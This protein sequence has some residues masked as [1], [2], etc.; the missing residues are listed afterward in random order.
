[1]AK[2][3]VH[4]VKLSF[5]FIPALLAAYC[6]VFVVVKV[7]F[8]KEAARERYRKEMTAAL[9][10]DNFELARACGERLMRWSGE[11]TSAD[12]MGWASSLAG[13]GELSLAFD[14]LNELAPNDRPGHAPAHHLKAEMLTLLFAQTGQRSLLPPLFF[15]LN[16]SDRQDSYQVNLGFATYY[17][18]TQQPDEAIPYLK[19]AAAED[20][21]LYGKLIT[22]YAQAQ[23]Q[24]AF[25]TT[26]RDALQ[27]VGELVEQEPGN[28]FSRIEYARLFLFAGR[29]D[30]GLAVLKEGQALNPSPE[31]DRAIA[32]YFMVRCDQT[33]DFNARIDWIKKSLEAD[34]NYPPPYGRLVQEFQQL[35]AQ[36]SQRGSEIIAIAESQANRDD[37]TALAHFTLASLAYLRGERRQYL[38]S[39]ER[40]LEKDPQYADAANNLAWEL[41][42]DEARMDLDRALALAEDLVK[43][44]PENPEYRDTYGTILLKRG[45]FES[46]L[47]ELEQVMNQ[48]ADKA[49]L[50]SKLAKIYDHLEK[51]GLAEMHREKSAEYSTGS[52]N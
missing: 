33:E 46:A 22:T 1:M 8:F 36:D 25:G 26:L 11:P 20:P 48:V 49:D 5:W 45:E 42:N 3:R 37:A 13:C 31:L 19:S 6:L 34:A 40:T 38:L 39:L 47:D 15:H 16:Q 30:Q 52:L 7:V 9:G 21:R 2:E 29:Q 10:E 4:E 18:A 14:Q 17:T 35:G 27:E 12:R 32:T 24:S 28:V 51:P 44:H 43:R 41:A 23:D 50:H